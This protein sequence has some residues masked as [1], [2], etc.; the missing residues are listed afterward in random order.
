MADREETLRKIEAFNARAAELQKAAPTPAVPSIPPDA[1]GED[2]LTAPPESLS[3]AQRIERQATQT[4]TDLA[5]AE[6]QREIAERARQQAE[7]KAID[8]VQQSGS[9][10]VKGALDTMQP[11]I[12]WLESI[13]TPMGIGAILALI[14]VFLM[15]VVPVDTAGNTRLKL[16][17][18]TI[19]GKTHLAPIVGASGDFGPGANTPPNIINSSPKGQNVPIDL[20]NMPDL[21]GL[22]FNLG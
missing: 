18:Y 11:P 19:T 4:S 1:S 5:N 20:S 15:A 22:D 10:T 7:G 21:T 16:I 3:T 9:D 2:I 6:R 17:W 14:V 12:R 13:P 8:K